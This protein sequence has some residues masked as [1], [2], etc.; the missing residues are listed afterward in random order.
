MDNTFINEKLLPRLTFNPGLALTGFRT[1]RPW[2]VVL[3]CYADGLIDENEFLLLYDINQ[4]KN[5][6]F[7]Y[8]NYKRFNYDV[9]DPA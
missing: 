5:S 1:T 7:P 2:N 3:E 4:S 6:E 8:E 9:M